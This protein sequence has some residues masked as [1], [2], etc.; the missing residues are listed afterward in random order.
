[1]ISSLI[2]NEQATRGQISP[3]KKHEQG[4][5]PISVRPI[6]SA[7][8]RLERQVFYNRSASLGN[9]M[10]ICSE[11]RSYLCRP[12]SCNSSSS[13]ESSSPSIMLNKCSDSCC[14]VLKGCL[15]F[16]P[17][18]TFSEKEGTA[19]NNRSCVGT[20]QSLGGSGA[21]VAW[22]RTRKRRGLRLRNATVSKQVGLLRFFT[23]S[24]GDRGIRHR[25][26]LSLHSGCNQSKEKPRGTGICQSLLHF[27]AA[28]QPAR[29]GSLS[30]SQHL[31]HDHSSSTQNRW[32]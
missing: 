11:M 5:H 14:A 6:W 12:P 20:V 15:P 1:M 24:C 30:V 32:K 3:D 21:L 2:V 19:A 7:T 27:T 17:G 25:R 4:D 8:I 31:V 10:R 13:R 18:L 23:N 26:S 29:G 22:S 28:L 9:W 16:C